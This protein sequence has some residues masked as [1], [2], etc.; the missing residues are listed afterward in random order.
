MYKDLLIALE[1]EG[2]T[3][4]EAYEAAVNLIQITIDIGV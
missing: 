3:T 2:L 1:D 4:E